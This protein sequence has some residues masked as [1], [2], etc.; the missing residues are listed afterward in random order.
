[1]VINPIAAPT[2]GPMENVPNLV[3][4]FFGVSEIDDNIIT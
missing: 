2:I 3:R 4:K 1:M